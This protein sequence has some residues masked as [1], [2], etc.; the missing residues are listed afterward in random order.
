MAIP[1]LRSNLSFSDAAKGTDGSKQPTDNAAAKWEETLGKAKKE[2]GQED[3]GQ[4]PRP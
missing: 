2:S 1:S 3:A 4:K